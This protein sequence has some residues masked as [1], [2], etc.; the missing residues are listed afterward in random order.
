MLLYFLFGISKK[1]HKKRFGAP[2]VTFDLPE[3]KERRRITP[4]EAGTID[5]TKL[6]KDDITATLFDL[7]IRKYIRIEAVEK[8]R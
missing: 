3:D 8:K 5:T 4:S 6:D 2:V 1:K 7:A